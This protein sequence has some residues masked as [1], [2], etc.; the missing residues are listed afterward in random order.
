MNCAE[1]EQGLARLMGEEAEGGVRARLLIELRGH[2]GACTDCRGSGDLLEILALPAGER[3]LADDP[4]EP[5]WSSFEWRL[6]PRLKAAP[7][8]SGGAWW[9]VAAAVVVL[10]L[11]GAWILLQPG[12][13]PTTPIVADAGTGPTATEAVPEEFPPSLVRSLDQASAA[14][15]EEQLA[16]LEDLGAGWGGGL[17]EPGWGEALF[18]ETERLDT[19]TKERLLEWLREQNRGLEGAQG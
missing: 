5:Y 13:A 8:R 18:P 11:V 9:L 10:S 7:A 12:E 1:F 14:E 3:E 16:A 6:K 19:E 15:V 17:A 4:G 2:A